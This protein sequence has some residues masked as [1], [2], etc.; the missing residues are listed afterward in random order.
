[1][2]SASDVR[3]RVVEFAKDLWRL[4]GTQCKNEAERENDEPDHPHGHLGG[5]LAGGESSRAELLAVW[6]SR[7]AAL[8]EHGYSM[9]WSARSSSGCGIVRPRAF[10]VFM[11]MT[12]SNLVGC[13]MG[14][15]PGEAPLRI[16]ST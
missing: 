7:V 3:E 13:W 5:G 1:M 15:S 9:I 8:V 14:R 10:A 2:P 12:N 4:D 16:L 6:L 11:L